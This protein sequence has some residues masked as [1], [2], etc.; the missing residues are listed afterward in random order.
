MNITSK[1]LMPLAGA[2]LGMGLL[3]SAG[4]AASAEYWLCAKAGSVTMP[5][6]VAPIPIW[7]YVQDNDADLTNGCPALDATAHRR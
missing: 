5:G 2:L 7:G 1:R 6:A 4:Q 3:L